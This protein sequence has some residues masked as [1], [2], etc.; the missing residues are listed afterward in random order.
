MQPKNFLDNP[1]SDHLIE[2]G[3]KALRRWLM[4]GETLRAPRQQLRPLGASAFVLSYNKFKFSDFI[5]ERT[6]SC[7][8]WLYSNEPNSHEGACQ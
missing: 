6:E 1:I 5:R 3:T 8:L 7:A 4:S 2:V